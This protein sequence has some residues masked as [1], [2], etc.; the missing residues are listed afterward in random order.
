MRLGVATDLDAYLG[1]FENVVQV[2][3]GRRHFF[4]Q[5]AAGQGRGLAALVGAGKEQHVVDD[6]AQAFEFFQVRL[7]HLEVMLGTAPPRQRHLGLADQV[8]QR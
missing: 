4:G 8:G 6:G 1:V 5:R 7:Q 2:I 3:E